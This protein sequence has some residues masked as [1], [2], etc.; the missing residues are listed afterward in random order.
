MN[1]DLLNVVKQIVAE[2]SESILSEPK[3]VSAFFSDL[4]RDVPK[5]QKN[6]LIKCLEYKFTQTLRNVDNAERANCK[7]KLVEKLH[8]EEGLDIV[9][10][11]NTIEL[12]AIVLFGEENLPAM[13]TTSVK[14]AP[15]VKVATSSNTFTDPRDGKVYRT[16]KIGGQV[17]MAENLAY[18]APDSK[19][20]DNDESNGSKYGRLYNWG[21][22]MKVCPNG[23]HLPSDKEWQTL[24]DF[25]GGD[26][27]A[28]KKL[29]AKSGWKANGNGTDD[30]GFSALPGGDGNSRGSFNNV[31]K[32]GFWW[33][34]REVSSDNANYWVMGYSYEH[35]SC[36]GFGGK[37][38]MYGS[39][40][41]VQD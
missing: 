24:V 40:R 20:Y 15:P 3:I 32:Y 18:N 38:Y 4:A 6:A 33:S 9:L 39:V 7:Q 26:E 35:A 13:V 8:N 27:I 16:V 12:L 25:A 28:G 29:K 34:S 31:G 11:R 22:A 2:R 5:P 17:W 14:V 21:T 19:V 41:C 23:W 37:S 10:C 30:F 36:P 1:T